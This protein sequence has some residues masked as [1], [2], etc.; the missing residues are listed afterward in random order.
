MG[1]RKLKYSI[2][3]RNMYTAIYGLICFDSKKEANS[4][5]NRLDNY[6][7]DEEL[8]FIVKNCINSCS[9]FIE[10]IN[11]RDIKEQYY[12]LMGRR[13]EYRVYNKDYIVVNRIS[14]DIYI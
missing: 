8:Y 2:E 13:I 10:E 12:T 9:E 6:L 11:Y 7:N 5:C 1:R 3:F 4:W 14:Y